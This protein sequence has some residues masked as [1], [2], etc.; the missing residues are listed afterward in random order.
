MTRQ[1]NGHTIEIE[2][3]EV[4]GHGITIFHGVL[5][6]KRGPKSGG[7]V[8]VIKADGTLSSVKHITSGLSIRSL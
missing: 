3:T 8:G 1:H 4:N 2:G 5:I 6:G 7:V